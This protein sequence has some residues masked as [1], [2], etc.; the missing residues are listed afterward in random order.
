MEKVQE[1]MTA[2]NVLPKLRLG[3]KKLK[4]GVKSTGPHTVKFL[5]EP[6]GITAKDFEGKPTKWLRFE[7]EEGGVRLHWK[8]RVLNREGEANYLLEKL[9]EIKIGDERV[10]EM[11]KQG[12]KNYI[13][14]RGVGAAAN[15]PDE[16]EGDVI[17]YDG[18]E[19]PGEK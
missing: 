5:A 3:L 7:V 9:L 6:E 16:D 18:E 14:I 2:L 11:L 13:D 4:G 17:R 12:A 15:E 19:E 10:L 1:V 8:V